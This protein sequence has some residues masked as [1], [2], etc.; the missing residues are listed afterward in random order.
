MKLILF[1]LDHLKIYKHES[2]VLQGLQEIQ[3]DIGMVNNTSELHLVIGYISKE[4]SN[5]VI[6]DSTEMVSVKLCILGFLWNKI[7]KYKKGN[8]SFVLLLDPYI[9]ILI[10]SCWWI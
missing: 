9:A 2:N 1:L 7:D 4:L 8:C 10:F 6:I 5:P 3:E